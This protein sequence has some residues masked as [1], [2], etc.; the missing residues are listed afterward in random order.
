MPFI[1][2]VSQL[3]LGAYLAAILDAIF[4]ITTHEIKP[5]SHFNLLATK[6]PLKIKIKMCFLSSMVVK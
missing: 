3:V 5:I 6:N 4:N 2:F 1:E